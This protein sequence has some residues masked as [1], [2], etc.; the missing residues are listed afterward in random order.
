MELKI[1]QDM[2]QENSFFD[3]GIDGL[4]SY[5]EDNYNSY[6]KQDNNQVDFD[7]N[8]NSISEFKDYGL[9]NCPNG[10]ESNNGVCNDSMQSL[11]VYDLHFD[12]Y[13]I[14]PNN[15]NY[16]FNNI[17]G[18]ENNNLWDY[19]DDNNNGVYDINE[20]IVDEYLNEEDCLLNSKRTCLI[21]NSCWG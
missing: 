5:Q 4:Y 2:T 11:H 1:I 8:D 19:Y 17:F 6:G 20:E 7:S 16:T 12:D 21:R 3:T 10:Y 13:D 9:D 15:D 14:D 18:T